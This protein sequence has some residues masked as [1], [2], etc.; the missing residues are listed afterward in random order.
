MLSQKF[1]LDLYN[2]S[3]TIYVLSPSIDK[4]FA[5]SVLVLRHSKFKSGEFG[6]LKSDKLNTLF[7]IL[8]N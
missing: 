2:N 5:Q 4:Y 1:T 7:K 6:F 8:L 3:S